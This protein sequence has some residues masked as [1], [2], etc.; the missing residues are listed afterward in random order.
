MKTIFDEDLKKLN[1]SYQIEVAM[2]DGFDAITLLFHF[3]GDYP[4]NS[5]PIFQLSSSWLKTHHLPILEAK[6]K[7]I[8]LT[9]RPEPVI[10]QWVQFLKNDSI[11][12]LGIEANAE[13][14]DKA[15][16]EVETSEPISSGS[17]HIL[18]GSPITD[19]KSK[20]QAFVAEVKSLE[21][22]HAVL[23][24]L[25]SN[26]KIAIATHNMYAY[27]IML[28][29]D[30]LLEDRD[31][32]G[33]G[34]AGDKILYVLQTRKQINL[35]V[36]VS[37]WYGGIHL[38]QARFK[39]IADCAVEAIGLFAKKK[40]GEG[41][42]ESKG[43]LRTS[44]EIFNQIKWDPDYDPATCLMGYMDRFEG[45]QEIEMDEF[46]NADIPFH[47]VWYFKLNGKV[48]WDRKTREDL[49]FKK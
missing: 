42:D 10:F 37:R 7:E 13:E 17:I 44:E 38:G 34:G 15:V 30:Q 8:Y 33:E 22:V 41:H 39:H 5:P 20:F 31:D 32:D 43:K 47:R 4:S 19:R 35:I 2:D 24:Q 46:K 29:P 3:P 49:L 14:A 21:D 25:K 1:E 45:M 40:E 36:V 28:K 23:Q 27:R 16:V 12:L 9:V 26:K 6:L 18:S 11:S 48:V